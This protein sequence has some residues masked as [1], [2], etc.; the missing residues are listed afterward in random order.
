MQ[1]IYYEHNYYADIDNA[2]PNIIVLPTATEK[3][4][5]EKCCLCGE[6]KERYSD[7]FNGQPLCEE[8]V[9]GMDDTHTTR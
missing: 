7:T 9:K 6:E 5:I 4:M 3:P 2:L 8:C 1:R